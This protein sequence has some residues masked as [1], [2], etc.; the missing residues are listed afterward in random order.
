MKKSI[1]LLELIEIQGATLILTLKARHKQHLGLVDLFD[2]LL[3]DV[4]PQTGYENTKSSAH[5]LYVELL[6]HVRELRGLGLGM[7]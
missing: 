2:D 5:G 3:Q 6:H 7:F 1:G 4:R